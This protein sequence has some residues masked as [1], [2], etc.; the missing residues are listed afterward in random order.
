M[1]YIYICKYLYIYI[2]LKH[3]SWKGF[4]ISY[5]KLQIPGNKTDHFPEFLTVNRWWFQVSFGGGFAFEGV[6]IRFQPT[7]QVVISWV[8]LPLCWEVGVQ[9]FCCCL[10]SGCNIPLER[11]S[12]EHPL[13]VQCLAVSWFRKTSWWLRHPVINHVGL[14]PPK[15]PDTKNFKNIKILERRGCEVHVHLR[16][17]KKQVD[18]IHRFL[19]PP[20]GDHFETPPERGRSFITKTLAHHLPSGNIA[21]EYAHFRLQ[22]GSIFHCY[23]SLRV[24][25]CIEEK[26]HHRHLTWWQ[27]C[28]PIS[29]AP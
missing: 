13:M 5:K 12:V 10:R 18:E 1:W 23:V 21:M 27:P 8:Y 20:K 29:E 9:N 7:W 6:A 24:R 14:S 28:Q 4:R 26:T 17:H 11:F 2:Y 25:E 16:N 3:W 15:F 22:S 19:T